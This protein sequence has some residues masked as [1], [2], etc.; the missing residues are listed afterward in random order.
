MDKKQKK[1]FMADKKFQCHENSNDYANQRKEAVPQFLVIVSNAIKQQVV[2][3][4]KESSSNRF[5]NDLVTSLRK[6]HS[7]DDFNRTEV[8]HIKPKIIEVA[9]TLFVAP[10]RDARHDI[11]K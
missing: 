5:V 1:I 10:I 9:F 4:Q 6:S 11:I 2:P 7:S 8:I 3:P